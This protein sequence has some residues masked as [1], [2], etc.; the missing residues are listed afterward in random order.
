V[1]AVVL[2]CAELWPFWCLFDCVL[3]FIQFWFRF[4]GVILGLS[5]SC[6]DVFLVLLLV[7]FRDV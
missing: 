5:R 3:R 4:L 6:L 1:F 2:Y 7:R